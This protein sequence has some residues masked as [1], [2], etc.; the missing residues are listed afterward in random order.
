M[1]FSGLPLTKIVPIFADMINSQKHVEVSKQELSLRPDYSF[2]AHFRV[3]DQ[4]GRGKIN[5]K[6]FSQSLKKLGV[7]N[8][9]NQL[10]SSLFDRFDLN[11]S[12]FLSLNELTN[13]LNPTRKEYQIL[14]KTRADRTEMSNTSSLETV[15]L[16]PFRQSPK[17]QINP[18]KK[19]FP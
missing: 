1:N 9:A 6:E 16:H 7:K 2:K 15:S 11:K 17:I 12:G 18:N 19:F 5:F 10:I 14:M 13:M 8:A 4:T 3:L